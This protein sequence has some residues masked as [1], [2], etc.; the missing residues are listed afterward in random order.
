MPWGL[1]FYY[2]PPPKSYFYLCACMC[3]YGFVH[4]SADRVWKR[5]RAPVVVSLLILCWES[6]KGLLQE[7]C[8]LLHSALSPASHLLLLAG[9]IHFRVPRERQP[10][11]TSIARDSML[12]I[13]TCDFTSPRM[14]GSP[15]AANSGWT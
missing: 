6:N 3:A 9:P 14:Q 1:V 13:G 11:N 10:M 8:M 4:V 12:G 15:K 2:F 5:A 7:P